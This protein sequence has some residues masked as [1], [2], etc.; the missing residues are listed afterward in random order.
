MER[1]FPVLSAG[2]PGVRSSRRIHGINTVRDEDA[3]SLRR[4]A[5]GIARSSWMPDVHCPEREITSCDQSTCPFDRMCQWDTPA[6]TQY[7]ARVRTGEW[8]DIPY[9]A[10]VPEGIDHLLVAGR[11]ISGT[12]MA[13]ASYRIQQTCL[14]TGEAAGV[15]AARAV[16]DNMTP[17][18]LD[19][20]SL[21]HTLE[22]RRD[23]EPAFRPGDLAL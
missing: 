16:A 18:G 21:A 2:A 1:V 22:A 19:T 15:A 14:S 11:C 5:D 23:V 20:A 10:L 13:Q 7:L 12:H 4:R 3:W 8:F 17:A 6:M 9:G